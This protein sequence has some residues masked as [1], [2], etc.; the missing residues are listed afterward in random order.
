MTTDLAIASPR[1]VDGQTVTPQEIEALKGQRLTEKNAAGQVIVVQKQP[2]YLLMGVFGLLALMMV[3]STA[4]SMFESSRI[5]AEKMAALSHE[6]TMTAIEG[7][8]RVA[9][10]A[11]QPRESRKPEPTDPLIYV[12]LFLGSAIIISMSVAGLKKVAG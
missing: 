2:P 3:L 4:W 5:S 7:M 8:S 10:A 11:S 6:Q 12:F 9:E 1:F